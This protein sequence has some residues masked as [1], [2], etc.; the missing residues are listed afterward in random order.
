MS[1]FGLDLTGRR[2]DFVK[3]VTKPRFHKG[4]SISWYADGTSVSQVELSFMNLIYNVKFGVQAHSKNCEKRLLASSWLSVRLS[5][6]NSAT[7]ERI[8]IKFDIWVF[9]E[10]LS[11]KLKFPENRTWIPGTLHEDRGHAVAQWLRHCTANRKVAGSIHDGVIG[12]FYW[13]NPS[14]RTMA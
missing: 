12:I 10:S 1:C 3:T 5:E 14:G 2:W 6:L 4:L 11:I 13:H 9:F 8:F 7:T